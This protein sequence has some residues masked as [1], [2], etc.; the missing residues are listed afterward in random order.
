M[1]RASNA[2]ALIAEAASLYDHDVVLWSDAQAGLLR[3]VA[4]GRRPV[5]IDWENIVEEIESVGRSQ[6]NAVESLLLQTL[7]HEF[8]IVLWPDTPY[9]EGWRNE[10]LLYQA[11]AG[12]HFTPSMRQKID[13]SKLVLRAARA[14][15][16]SIDGVEYSLQSLVEV[17]DRAQRE[18]SAWIA[19]PDD[20]LTRKI[21]LTGAELPSIDFFQRGDVT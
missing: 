2:A 21:R 11:Q 18:V 16:Q 19:L 9:V 12:Q 15:P 13:I 5:G 6:V 10:S 8:K 14:L 1:T 20:T 17:F 3:Q 7:V 4:A